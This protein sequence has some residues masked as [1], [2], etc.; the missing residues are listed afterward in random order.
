MLVACKATAERN[1]RH[2]KQP[3]RTGEMTSLVGTKSMF[4]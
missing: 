4:L 2:I 3:L 1:G